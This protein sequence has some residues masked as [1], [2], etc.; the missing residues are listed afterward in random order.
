MNPGSTE[1]RATSLV[2][3]RV[4]P[5][6]PTDRRQR[7]WLVAA[8]FALA[9]VLAWPAAARAEI[10][11]EAFTGV[12]DTSSAD[13]RVSQPAAGNDFTVKDLAFDGRSFDPAPYYG[14]RAMYFFER[15]PWLGVGAEWFHF[16]IYGETAETR[17]IVGTRGGV[18]Y[19]VT[20]PVDSTVQRFNLPNGVS[21][22]TV[23]VM[24]RHGWFRDPD[25]YPGGRLQAYLGGGVG[26]VIAYPVSVIEGIRTT[27][28]YEV[29]GVGVQGFAGIR[30]M[31]F[32]HLGVFLEGKLTHSSL[33]VGV[34][35]GGEASLDETTRHL[36]G[37][38]TL[39]IP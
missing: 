25:E 35:R 33:T 39:A 9:A 32:K 8:A 26:P 15:L 2:A 30:V 10:T 31:L 11:F 16:K 36:V 14:F 7:E 37:G 20:G 6:R 5:G 18:P 1:T 34:A 19:D 22:V 13:L 21:Y 17:R 27:P 23:D 3:P 28:G 4:R 38:I 24:A 12:S 29:A